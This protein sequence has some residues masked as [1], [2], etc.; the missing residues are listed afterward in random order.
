MNRSRNGRNGVL[1]QVAAGVAVV[2]FAA[3]IVG[4]IATAREVAVQSSRI[5]EIDRQRNENRQALS[6]IQQSVDK[7]MEKIGDNLT[8][9][10]A[11]LTGMK[12]QL[13]QIERRIGLL[14]SRQDR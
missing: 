5:A 6:V 14:E 9:V 11:E 10:K 2:I 12:V 13:G 4:S 7:G 3:A 8:D 1:R